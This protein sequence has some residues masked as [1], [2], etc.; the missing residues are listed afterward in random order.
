MNQSAGHSISRRNFI[1][2]ASL[3]PLSAAAALA[4]SKLPSESD[5]R[6]DKIC[7]AQIK[8]Y[9][10]KEDLATNHKTMM[11]ILSAIEKE[12]K[13]DVLITP[14]GFLDGYVATV[15]SVEK[16]DMF[17]Y[18]IDPETSEYVKEVSKWAKRT[19][20]WMIYG[21]IRKAAAGIFN[22][23]LIINRKGR[24]IGSY[25]KLHIQT[26]DYK[27]TPGKHLDV[28]DSDFGKFGVMICADRRWPETSRTLALKG[29]R[30]IMN[31][32]YGFKGSLNTAMMRTRA[33]ENGIYI[34]FTHPGQSLITA[35][36]GKVL[37]DNEDKDKSFTITEI[38]LS[39]AQL[40]K[41]GHL[42]DRRTDVYQL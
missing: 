42:R 40:D 22:T 37:C 32:T 18:A 19:N 4:E 31:P 21:C 26:H 5:T 13:I 38:D 35:P 39:K 12:G 29:A 23:A 25:D 33:Y 34:A 9:P 3:V 20:T 17:K 16:E 36:D 6:L 1:K 2:T 30:I 24:L 10:V 8:V 11:E 7:I 27:Y 14:E 28:Y 15:K 41:H